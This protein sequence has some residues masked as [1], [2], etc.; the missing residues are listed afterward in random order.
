MIWHELTGI[1]FLMEEYKEFKNTWTVVLAG[2]VHGISPSSVSSHCL[3]FTSPHPKPHF[4][5]K[6][7]L[8]PP[9]SDRSSSEAAA[10]AVQKKP[11]LDSGFW[12][13]MLQWDERSQTSRDLQFGL[14]HRHW[15]SQPSPRAEG[16]SEPRRTDLD[17]WQGGT[18]VWIPLKTHV[19][20]LVTEKN[21]PWRCTFRLLT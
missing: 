21:N 17:L 3:S 7:G 2:V 5:T 9:A 15:S 13:M 4:M 10:E 16:Y 1:S 11:V 20:F 6:H 12:T 18:G 8:I 19:C 14:N